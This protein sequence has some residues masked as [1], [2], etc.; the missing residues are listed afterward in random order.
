M[1]LSATYLAPA[2]ESRKALASCMPTAGMDSSLRK[3]IQKLINSSVID[4]PRLFIK[5]SD[6]VDVIA[7]LSLGKA[8]QKD[9]I[10]KGLMVNRGAG[11]VCL[12][13]DGRSEVGGEFAVAGHVSL[14]WR[15]WE[16]TWTSRCICGGYWTTRS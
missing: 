1:T 3:V 7:Q 14:R 10:T 2:D 5:P 12:R 15:A 9:V 8:T 4:K 11:L 16:K 6:L 13:C